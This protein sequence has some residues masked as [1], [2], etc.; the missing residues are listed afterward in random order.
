MLRTAYYDV[1]TLDTTAADVLP[2]KSQRPATRVGT[3][4]Q[5][6]PPPFQNT[7]HFYVRNPALDSVALLLAEVSRRMSYWRIL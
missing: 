7:C 6:Q 3:M 4:Y 5:R 2:L 1:L